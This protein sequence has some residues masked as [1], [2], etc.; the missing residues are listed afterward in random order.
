MASQLPLQQPCGLF[1]VGRLWIEGQSTA[2]QLNQGPDL[3]DQ[4][5]D[6]VPRQ[7]HRGE[8]LQEVQVPD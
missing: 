6:G 7:E 8:D 2:S 4:G 3:E 5:S 1:C